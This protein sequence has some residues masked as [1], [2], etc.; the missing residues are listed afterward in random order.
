MDENLNLQKIGQIVEEHGEVIKEHSEKIQEHSD[1]INSIDNKINKLQD[2]T[3]Q[4][5]LTMAEVQKSQM[6]VELMVLENTNAQSKTLAEFTNK[7]LD[8]FTTSIIQKNE[9]NNK[10]ELENVEAK[11][12]IKL[13]KNKTNNKIKFLSAKETWALIGSL[14]T[15][16][17]TYLANN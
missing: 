10:I 9:T 4:L 6:K 17:I 14:I 13:D 2:T 16:L 5:Q 15:F 3:V 7:I 1:K 11:N 8:T 12:E